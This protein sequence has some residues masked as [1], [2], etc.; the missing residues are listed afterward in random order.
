MELCLYSLFLFLLWSLVIKSINSIP[1]LPYF[2]QAQERNKHIRLSPEAPGFCLKSISP[3]SAIF[4][5]SSDGWWPHIVFR[6]RLVTVS[7]PGTRL[8]RPRIRGKP[9]WFPLGTCESRS[10]SRLDDPGADRFPLPVWAELQPLPLLTACFWVVV[11]TLRIS[12]RPR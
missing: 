7:S 5:G 6:E 12:A 4:F 9:P 2:A 11:V 3:G 10:R 8:E 1:E